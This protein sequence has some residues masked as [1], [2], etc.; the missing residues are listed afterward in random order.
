MSAMTAS[1]AECWN[2]APISKALPV[3]AKT[4]SPFVNRVER[5]STASSISS[6]KPILVPA[7]HFVSDREQIHLR[8]PLP[9]Y[10]YDVVD[11]RLGIKISLYLAAFRTLVRPLFFLSS[12]FG[13]FVR[14]SRLIRSRDDDRS[15]NLVERFVDL[16]ERDMEIM[17]SSPTP[18]I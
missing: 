16:I 15:L 9:Y 13:F 2:Q 3:V 18:S 8:S 17:K 14:F 4:S 12:G 1:K 11:C 5:Q 7:I 6:N 10:K